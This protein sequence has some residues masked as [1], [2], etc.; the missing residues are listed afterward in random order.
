MRPFLLLLCLSCAVPTEAP[1]RPLPPSKESV[2]AFLDAWHRAASEHDLAGYLGV[3]AEDG[4]FLGTDAG[5][6]WTKEQ[7]RAYVEP[8]FERGQGWTYVPGR[9]HVAIEGDLVWFDE[10]LT[11][12]G[13]GALRGTGVLRRRGEGLELVQYDLH[14][15]VPNE[16]AREVVERIRTSSRASSGSE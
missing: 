2:A 4:V 14:F 7:F 16:V 9:R 12:Q 3:M 5:E 10:L 6:R 8:Y 1:P 15:T 11:N 13:Y